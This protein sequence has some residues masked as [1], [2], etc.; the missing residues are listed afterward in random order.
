[1]EYFVNRINVDSHNRLSKIMGAALLTL[2]YACPSTA[3]MAQQA[4]PAQA[5]PATQITQA[6]SGPEAQQGPETLRIPVGHSLLIKT[7]SR[8]KR[9]LTGNPAVLESVLTS[10]NE[11]VLT[12]KQTGGS[13]L[14]LWDEAGQSRMIDVVADV[15]VNPL[16]NAIE[17]SYPGS[18]VD[19]QSQEGK[20]VLVGTVPSA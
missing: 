1:M 10:P 5:A 13:S 7:Q 20:I 4:P 16:R 8:V 19:V 12:A 18:S 9:I 2:A 17:Q 15:D 3:A 6:P 14:L 11:V